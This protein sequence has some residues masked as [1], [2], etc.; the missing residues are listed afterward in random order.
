[1]NSVKEFTEDQK[2]IEDGDQGLPKFME[3]VA[4]LTDSDKDDP[5]DRDTV[6]LMTVHQAKGVEYPVVFVIGMEESLFPSMMSMNSRADLEEERTIILCSL[7]TCR[8][9]GL[10]DSCSNA[11]PLGKAGRL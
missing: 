7:N 5:K 2:E 10:P 11:L 6:S 1:M 8:K 3:D 9:R 4:L